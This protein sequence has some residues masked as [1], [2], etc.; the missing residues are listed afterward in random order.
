M[1][2][3]ALR[4]PSP[5]L[6][7]GCSFTRRSF[8]EG[9]RPPASAAPDFF[10]L[11]GESG[12][13]HPFGSFLADKQRNDGPRPCRGVETSGIRCELLAIIDALARADHMQPKHMIVIRRRHLDGKQHLSESS[14]R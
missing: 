12:G 1:R 10:V 7:R 3:V 9:G 6:W 2:F 5:R 13:A 4:P 8:S 14:G 11:G